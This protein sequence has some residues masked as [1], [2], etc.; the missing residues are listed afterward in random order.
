MADVSAQEALANRILGFDLLRGL[1]AMAVAGYHLTSWSGIATWHNA[2]T[3]GVYTFFVL[4]AASMT[5]AYQNRLLTLTD[6]RA[7]FAIRYARIVPLFGLVLVVAVWLDPS[8]FVSN[9][10]ILNLSMLFSLGDPGRL[11]LIVGGWSLGIEFMFYALFPMMLLLPRSAVASSLIVL[12]AFIVQFAFVSTAVSDAG[13]LAKNWGTYTHILSYIGFFVSGMY[14]P[15]VVAWL[16]RKGL[17]RSM[18]GVLGFAALVITL[19]QNGQTAEDTLILPTSMVFAGLV[20]LA[21]AGFAVQEFGAISSRVA[22][23][24]GNVSYGVY[25]F[26]PLSYEMMG[27]RGLTGIVLVMGSLGLTFV[28]AY[29][30]YRFYERPI[31]DMCKRRL[32]NGAST[33]TDSPRARA[34]G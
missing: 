2:G 4:S 9:K 25:L 18:G 19:S 14:L 27:R 21:C 10:V 1:C 26:H 5:V 8:R 33:P 11:S 6:L 17:V 28:L 34:V 23:F 12:S 3:Y 31:L 24:F 16:R 32:R 29:F 30:A 13:D 15:H 22:K 7:Y 20:L